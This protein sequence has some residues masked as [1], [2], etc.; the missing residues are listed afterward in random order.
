MYDIWKREKIDTYSQIPL[1][2]KVYPKL[3]SMT[4]AKLRN[5]YLEKQFKNNKK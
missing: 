2:K 3:D 5:E 4:R 1:N